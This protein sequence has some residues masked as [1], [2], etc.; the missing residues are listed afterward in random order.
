MK[1]KVKKTKTMGRGVFADQKIKARQ[2]IEVSPCISWDQENERRIQETNL[3]N[4]V[5]SN[6][7]RGSVLALGFGSLFNHARGLETNVTYVYDSFNNQ[8]KFYATKNIKKGEQLFINYGYDP[9]LQAKKEEEL[10]AR[11]ADEKKAVVFATEPEEI[12][13]GPSLQIEPKPSVLTKLCN[14][15]RG[16][17]EISIRKI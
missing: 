11:L 12:F 13:P 17:N 16:K 15:L 10:L 5:F 9:V 8:M 2:L 14:F 7:A 3:R 4:Y 1:L 6:D